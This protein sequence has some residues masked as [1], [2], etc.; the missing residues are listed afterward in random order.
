MCFVV[1]ESCP[2]FSLQGGTAQI[3]DKE[4]RFSR[5]NGRILHGSRSATCNSEGH[6]TYHNGYPACVGK[7]M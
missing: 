4:A 3:R 1:V 7:D 6:W 2:T 5:Y